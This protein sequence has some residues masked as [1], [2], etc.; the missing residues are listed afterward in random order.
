GRTVGDQAEGVAQVSSAVEGVSQL[1]QEA[2]ATSE[3]SAAAAE[4]LAGQAM[5]LQAL[6]GG[7]NLST[8][9][10]DA[11]PQGDASQLTR[12]IG[13]SKPRSVAPS[14]P[15]MRATSESARIRR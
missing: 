6:V 13:K 10:A 8:G 15:S 1:T 11:R 12:R 14:P 2:A 4:E 5:Q 7:F 3:E 9:P